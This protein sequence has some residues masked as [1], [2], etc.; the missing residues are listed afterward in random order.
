[1]HEALG[2][3]PQCHTSQVWWCMTVILALGKWRQVDRPFTVL[4]N[5]GQFEDRLGLYE[6]LP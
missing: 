1:M 4:F 5:Y 6:V 2:S 3:N